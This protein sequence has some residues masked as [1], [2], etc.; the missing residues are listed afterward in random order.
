M[1]HVL[2][3]QVNFPDLGRC[4]SVHAATIWFLL[5]PRALTP[6]VRPRHGQ[7]SI[8]CYALKPCLGS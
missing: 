1:V 7:F 6:T 5:L 2:V 8:D 3:F 4:Q